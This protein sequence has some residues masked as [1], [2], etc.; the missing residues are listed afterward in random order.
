MEY[1]I[2]LGILV[3]I[4]LILAQ[5]FNLSFG[6]GKLFNL[7]HIAAYALGAYT[8]AL[9]STDHA[10]GTFVCFIASM[11]VAGLLAILIGIISLKLSQDYFAIGTLAFSA[12][13]TALLINWKSLTRGVLGIPGIPRP[14]IAN[15]DFDNLNFLYL[16]TVLTVLVLLVSYLLFNNAYGRSLRTQSEFEQGAIA[17][18]KNTRKLRN[19]AFF[20]SSA[21]AGLAGSL[22]AYY[23]NYIDP[24]SFSLVEM[25]FVL[26]LVITGRPGSFWGVSLAT[27]F[28]VLLPEPLRFIDMPSSILGPLRQ[29]L[30]AVIMFAVVYFNRGTIFPKE[31]AI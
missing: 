1:L 19:F 5:S 18:G 12:I 27:I 7:A 29:L 2:H 15:I 16:S 25:I 30:Y 3:C 9:L 22:F 28:L 31:R 10:I 8:T 11:L 26:T 23:I 24:S 14:E 20:V 4:Y 17:L 6:L 13:V 21:I